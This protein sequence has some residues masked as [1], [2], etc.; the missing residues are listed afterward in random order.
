MSRFDAAPPEK[1]YY[2]PAKPQGTDPAILRNIEH[3]ATIKDRDW[4]IDRRI[5]LDRE[6]VMAY[7]KHLSNAPPPDPLDWARMVLTRVA[8][9][10]WL[11]SLAI[12]NAQE[13][14]KDTE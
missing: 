13:A 11:P 14:L 1:P 2:A 4:L 10:E 12:K 8:D 6:S 9:G 7:A 5:G 3:A